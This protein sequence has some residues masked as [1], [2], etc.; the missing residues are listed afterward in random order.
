MTNN[1]PFQ[2]YVYRKDLD[3]SVRGIPV[4]SVLRKHRDLR[5]LSGDVHPPGFS[6]HEGE[7]IHLDLSTSA[8]TD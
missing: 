2:F 6:F 3:L 8:F 1:L 4:G 5:S 7:G